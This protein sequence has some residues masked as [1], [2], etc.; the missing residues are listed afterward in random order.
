MQSLL[1][2]CFLFVVCRHSLL[3]F[4]RF[5]GAVNPNKSVYCNAH[6][7]TL[8]GPRSSGTPN[9]RGVL[10]KQFIDR[11]SQLSSGTF[12][13]S[14]Q[15]SQI[16]WPECIE[17][18]LNVSDHLALTLTVLPLPLMRNFHQESTG[19]RP[20]TLERSLS[21]AKCGSPPFSNIQQ[22]NHLTLPVFHQ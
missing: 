8:V 5:G 17:H 11:N 16:G 7:G 2:Y 15:L 22:L 6:L 1:V 20:F 4:T 19:T 18:R 13:S 12:H 21:R 10:L 9:S 14:S 3:L